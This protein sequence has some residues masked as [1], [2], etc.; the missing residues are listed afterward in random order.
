M[1]IRHRPRPSTTITGLGKYPACM[2]DST[3]LESSPAIQL[4]LWRPVSFNRYNTRTCNHNASTAATGPVCFSTTAT[5][6]VT[7][8]C[9][10]G[11]SMCFTRLRSSPID[12]QQGSS[13]AANHQQPAQQ[14]APASQAV[15][16]YY[17]QQAQ[18][19]IPEVSQAPLYY[20]QQQPQAQ[21]GYYRQFPSEVYM[22]VL[23]L[24]FD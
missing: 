8:Y 10:S 13:Q 7:T 3:D 2:L 21:Q 23:S 18:Q 15:P 4:W 19:Q 5:A 20:H 1:P 11:L 16:H 24:N 17:Q 14:V 22:L 9:L 6:C 12:G